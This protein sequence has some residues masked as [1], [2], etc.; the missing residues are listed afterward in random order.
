MD[1]DT[2]I[3]TVYCLVA[4]HYKML[5]NLSHIRKGGFPPQLTDEEVITM[6][7]CG[8]FFKLH[9]DKDLFAYFHFH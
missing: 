2:F 1:R 6:E 7:I 9:T 4:E 3:I 5:K 8:A